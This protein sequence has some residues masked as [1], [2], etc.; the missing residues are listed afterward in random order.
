MQRL[1]TD[2]KNRVSDYCAFWTSLSKT[3]YD[4]LKSHQNR[5]IKGKKDLFALLNKAGFKTSR[6][7]VK[8]LYM[9]AK[10][11]LIIRLF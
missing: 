2:N 11:F 9:I 6:I 5:V 10:I 1:E 3:T 4:N 8:S 7:P